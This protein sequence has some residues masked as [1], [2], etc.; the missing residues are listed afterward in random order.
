MWSTLSLPCVALHCLI[1]FICLSWCSGRIGRSYSD[2]CLEILTGLLGLKQEHITSG[3]THARFYECCVLIAQGKKE[4]MLRPIHSLTIFKYW[5]TWS[6]V[7]H[8]HRANGD[9]QNQRCQ[10]P[11]APDKK[12]RWNPHKVNGEH[13]S[14][15]SRHSKTL[16]FVVNPLKSATVDNYGKRGGKIRKMIKR[17]MI[18]IVWLALA[19]H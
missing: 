5:L 3:N 17:H 7:L 14:S 16:L 15:A 10:I 13:W 18:A 1:V 19:P 12:M 9:S 4:K 2:Q 6:G 8:L 11:L